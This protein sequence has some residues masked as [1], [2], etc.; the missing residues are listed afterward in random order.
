MQD[1]RLLDIIE[2]FV[3]KIVFNFLLICAREFHPENSFNVDWTT[4]YSQWDDWKFFVNFGVLRANFI[5]RYRY[6]PHC[7]IFFHA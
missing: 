2:E 3:V 5:Y 6:R 7:Q 1:W 4:I